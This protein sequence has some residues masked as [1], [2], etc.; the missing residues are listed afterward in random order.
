V[1]TCSES[2]GWDQVCQALTTLY[3]GD[4]CGTDSTA[5]WKVLDPASGFRGRLNRLNG[6]AMRL[7]NEQAPANQVPCSVVS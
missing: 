7:M 6:E 2:T 3:R 1:S 4:P 5:L